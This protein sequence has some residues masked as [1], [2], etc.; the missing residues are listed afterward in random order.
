M[1]FHSCFSKYDFLK[2]SVLNFENKIFFSNT[3][4]ICEEI[5]IKIL[6]K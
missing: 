2:N 3:A 1:L 4:D 6:R 5:K